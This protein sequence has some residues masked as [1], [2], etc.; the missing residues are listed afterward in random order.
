MSLRRNIVANYL[1][2]I[3]VTIIGIALVP[4]YIKHMGA[5]AYGLV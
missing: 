1:S 5:E 4:L 3:Y 2:Q